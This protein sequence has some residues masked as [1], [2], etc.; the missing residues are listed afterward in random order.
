MKRKHIQNPEKLGYSKLVY[1]YTNNFIITHTYKGQVLTTVFVYH[2][3]NKVET[4]L[5]DWT[6]GNHTLWRDCDITLY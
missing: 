6:S 5:F 2:H 3:I 1:K 4:V